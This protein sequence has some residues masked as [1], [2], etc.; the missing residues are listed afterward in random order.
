MTYPAETQK[1]GM[2]GMSY[3]SASGGKL[4]A[5]SLTWNQSETGPLAGYKSP[6]SL[7]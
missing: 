2:F 1:A 7:I 5:D 4:N 3:T 6:K